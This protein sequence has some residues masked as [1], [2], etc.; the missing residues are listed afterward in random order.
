MSERKNDCISFV[1]VLFFYFFLID[2]VLKQLQYIFAVLSASGK[3]SFSVLTITLLELLIGVSI[4]I[5]YLHVNPS[6]S[7]IPRRSNYQKVHQDFYLLFG[8][9]STT[10]VITHIS[11][12]RF[13]L[14][15]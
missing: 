1:L 15:L 7:V 10:P 8:R 2:A 3:S 5:C 13:I 9:P 11:Y 12:S 4:S 6:F 14:I